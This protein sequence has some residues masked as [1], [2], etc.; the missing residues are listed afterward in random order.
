MVNMLEKGIDLEEI[1][2][3]KPT[4]DSILKETEKYPDVDPKHKRQ[5]LNL[6]VDERAHYKQGSEEFGV[7]SLFWVSLRY[8]IPLY[9]CSV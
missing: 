4:L 2:K 7:F 1:R 5:V 8:V 3:S 6:L 9:S